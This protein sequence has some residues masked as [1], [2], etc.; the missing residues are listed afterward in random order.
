MFPGINKL[1]SRQIIRQNSSSDLYLDKLSVW[2][3]IRLDVYLVST[4][5]SA[6][7]IT[8]HAQLIWG[9][10]IQAQF[11]SISIALKY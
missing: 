11:F 4:I 10:P 8:D 6:I 5:N 3:I 7:M 2:R 9:V 1:I